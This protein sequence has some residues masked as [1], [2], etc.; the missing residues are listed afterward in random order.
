MRARLFLFIESSH[1][2]EEPRPLGALLFFV[3]E[4]TPET[5]VENG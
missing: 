4:G 2:R 1:R 5:E 3:A